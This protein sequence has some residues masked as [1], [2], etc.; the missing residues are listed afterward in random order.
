MNIS[1][2][3]IRENIK[4]FLG[5]ESTGSIPCILSEVFLKFADDGSLMTRNMDNEVPNSIVETYTGTVDNMPFSLVVYKDMAFINVLKEKTDKSSPYSVS[6]A[7]ITLTRA[8]FQVEVLLKE[9]GICEFE[10]SIAGL[11]GRITKEIVSIRKKA[12]I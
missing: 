9:E 11:L 7:K 12:S 10:P 4:K 3:Q 1:K 8:S 2:E 5:V 6:L